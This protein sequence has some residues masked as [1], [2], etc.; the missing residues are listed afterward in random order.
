MCELARKIPLLIYVEFLHTIFLLSVILC[1]CLAED[2]PPCQRMNFSVKMVRTHH[3]SS[4]LGL[5]CHVYIHILNP[6]SNKFCIPH[7]L[8]YPTTLA[9][10]NPVRKSSPP[11]L[12]KKSVLNGVPMAVDQWITCCIELESPLCDDVPVAGSC[13]A[14]SRENNSSRP[15]AFNRYEQILATLAG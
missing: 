6:R 13:I 12:K 2:H 8:S 1:R 3:V 9:D 11:L 5:F 4:F 10:T 7:L 15:T 14:G